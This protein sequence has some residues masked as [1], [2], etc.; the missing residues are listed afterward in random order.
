MRKSIAALGLAGLL[1]PGWAGA[2]TIFEKVGTVGSQ[3]LEIS[4]GARAVAMGGAF[5]GVADDAT[6]VYWNAAGIARIDPEKSELSLNHANWPAGLS[7][8]QM[9]YV[10]HMRRIPGAFAVHAR[11]LTM[12]PMMV[13]TA[14]QPNGTGETFDAGMMSVG[15]TYA[16][17]F[18]DKFSAGATGNFVTEGLAEYSQQ[19]MAFDIGT[20]YDVGTLG[21]RIGMSI[22]N[23]GSEI[24]FIDRPARLPSM[25]RVGTSA[26]LMQ[27]ADQKL[28]GS[29][30]FSHPPDNSER[31]NLGAEYS[32]RKYLFLRGGYGFNYDSEGIAGGIG[33]HVPV[34][35]AGMADVDYAFT[36]M[37]D[38]GG[39]HRFSLTFQF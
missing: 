3:F 13:T 22:S 12:Q 28:I 31:L 27:R 11:A 4:V 23:I 20:L 2:A 34:S 25:F 1:V 17:S 7:F 29:L 21:M 33:F 14:Y 10:F 26:T 32:F 39:V 35:V 24:T 16:R 19:A 8:D 18:T 30:E 36:D 5:V 15:L 38:L 37:K 9:S 6:S